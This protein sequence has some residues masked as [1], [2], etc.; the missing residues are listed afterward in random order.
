VSSW[1][2]EFDTLMDQ[3]KILIDSYKKIEYTETK[4]LIKLGDKMQELVYKML[5]IIGDKNE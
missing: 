3:Y 2:K 4:K 1:G 5:D